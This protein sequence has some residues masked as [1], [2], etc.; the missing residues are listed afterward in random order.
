MF[1]FEILATKLWWDINDGLL[2][3]VC[4]MLA[5]TH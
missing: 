3:G 1:L 2:N 5:F 4:G